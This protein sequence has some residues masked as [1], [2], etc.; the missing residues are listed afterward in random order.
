M[1][2]RDYFRPPLDLVTSWE[3]F[4]GGW[5]AVTVLHLRK[6]LP[7]G[8]VA[9]PRVHFGSQ[10]EIDVTAFQKYEA[11]PLSRLTKRNAGMPT[12]VWAPAEPRASLRPLDRVKGGRFKITIGE[13]FH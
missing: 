4:Y 5:P 3:G 2:L 7:S 9:E 11:P 10:V 13:V 6:L 8:Y 12:A 1:P